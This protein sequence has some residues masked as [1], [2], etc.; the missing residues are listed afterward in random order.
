MF[1]NL[2]SAKFDKTF[3]IFWRIEVSENVISSD[4]I[5]KFKLNCSNEMAT[6]FDSHLFI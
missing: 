4:N 1:E 5:K 2:I 3:F 6:F